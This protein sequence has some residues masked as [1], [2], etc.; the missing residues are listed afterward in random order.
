MYRLSQ[1]KEMRAKLK[2]SQLVMK[3]KVTSTKVNS[4]INKWKQVKGD[5]DGKDKPKLSKYSEEEE[6]EGNGNEEGG[7]EYDDEE[8]NATP[9]QP[10]REY[11]HY[12]YPNSSSQQ[13]QQQPSWQNRS[14]GSFGSRPKPKLQI[15][16][17]IHKQTTD[18]NHPSYS[19]TK[20][21]SWRDKLAMTK[22]DYV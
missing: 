9:Q 12:S 20:N 5:K 13:Q 14:N 7:E 4:L 22:K 11:Y 8:E 1:S 17:P 3:S 21:M 15:A 2:P 10:P 6:G 19:G 18:T 16:A